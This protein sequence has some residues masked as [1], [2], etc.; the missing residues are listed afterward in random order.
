MAT[1]III[2]IIIIMII[3]VRII[4][5]I[6][7]PDPFLSN[8]ENIS[9]IVKPAFLKASHNSNK[10]LVRALIDFDDD[11]VVNSVIPIADDSKSLRL[12]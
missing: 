11:V 6:I 7:T 4:I 3:I 12:L 9:T 5:Y 8:P 1:F 10:H 2:P